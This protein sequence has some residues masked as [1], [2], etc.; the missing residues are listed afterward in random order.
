MFRSTV[1]KLSGLCM[2]VSLTACTAPE[3]KQGA[4]EVKLS[5]GIALENFD[6]S[7]SPGNDFYR[8][9]NG[10]WLEQTEIPAEKSNYGSFSVLADEAEKHLL[11]IIDEASE[12]LAPEGSDEQKVGAMYAS[13]MDQEM[14]NELGSAPLAPLLFKIEALQDRKDLPK[15]L[16]DMG[17]WGVT[18][19]LG[20]YIYQDVKN[21]EQYTAYLWQYGLGLPDRDYYLDKENEKFADIRQKYLVHLERMLNLVGEDGADKKAQAIMQF[22]TALAE[23]SW[24]RVKNRDDNLTYN[25]YAIANLNEVM[26]SFD[27]AMYLSESGVASIDSVVVSQPSFFEAA[28]T[29]FAESDLDTLKAYLKWHSVN[30]FAPYLSDELVEANFDFYGKTLRGVPEMRPRWKRGVQ[31]VEDSLG[32][33]LGK[34]YVERHFPPEAKQRMVH[35]VDMLV[36]AY[37]VSINDLDWMS[38]E[39][40]VKALEKLSKFNVK[41]GYPDKWKDYSAL[42]V[43]KGDLLGNVMRSRVLEHDRDMAKL[44]QPIDKSEWHMTP[45]T[46]NAYYNPPANEIVFPAAI[47]QAPFFNLEAEDAVNYGAIGSVIGHEIGHGFDDQGS[48]YDGDGVL[49]NWWTDSDRTAFEARTGALISQFN[50]FCPLAED[51]P[52]VNG[53]LTIGENIG[54][55]GGLWIALKA[56]RLSLEGEAAPELDGFTGDQRVFLGW[57]QIWRRL[58][59][60]EE[61]LNRLKTDPHSPSEYRV[62]GIVRNIPDWY[63][64]FDVKEG[65]A[66]Y[67]APADR[68][69]IW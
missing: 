45:Q 6:H 34:I 40:R 51:Q 68:V 65:E 11:A 43:K 49:Q 13:F 28:N 56:Y 46:V 16:A 30:E 21:P 5:S 53:E 15:L 41:I 2:A 44:G 1:L 12:S 18:T 55:L 33:V 58:Y 59:R 54:D 48:K 3:P 17:R 25:K 29:L 8:Y 60:D 22:E 31:L 27:L 32:E 37:R 19:P 10:K 38:D 14:A 64:V 47:L 23:A 63:E 35:L 66:L 24:T 4:S 9:V 69:K 50:D 57:G 67:L 42:E 26:P 36:E 62:N 61:L 39:T 52:C 20:L 7:V